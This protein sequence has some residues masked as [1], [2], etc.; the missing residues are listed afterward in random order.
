M[1]RSSQ[2]II[3]ELCSLLKI[4]YS[5]HNSI[6]ICKR[7]V[8]AAYRI[9]WECVMEQRVGV[10]RKMCGHTAP[11]APYTR[12]TQLLS[13]P[14]AIQKLGAENRMLQLNI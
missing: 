8:V 12:P 11:S 5:I 7:G 9:V 3:R 6:R 10:R 4:Y 1:F 2:I 13:R 14:P